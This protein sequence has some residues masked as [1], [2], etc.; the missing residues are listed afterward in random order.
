MGECRVGDMWS[1]SERGSGKEEEWDREDEW[2][3]GRVGGW[4]V[5]ESG[6]EG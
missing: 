4:V 5:G 3:R 2:E 1:G 6:R